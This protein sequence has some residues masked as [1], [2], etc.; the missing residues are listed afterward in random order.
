MN[1][2]NAWM[3][4]RSAVIIEA[5]GNQSEA[6]RLKQLAANVSSTVREKLYV[7]GYYICVSYAC[8]MYAIYVW[9]IRDIYVIRIYN[10]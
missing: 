10:I 7:A 9:Y 8:D 6:A 5:L 1:A 2:A 3:M 4:R